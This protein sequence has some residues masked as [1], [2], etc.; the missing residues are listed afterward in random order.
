M[1]NPLVTIIMPIYNT[2]GYI[3]RAVESVLNQSFMDYE[4]LLVNDGST[5][6]SEEECQRMLQLDDRILYLSQENGGVASARNL[7]LSRARGEYVFFLDSDDTW[8]NNLLETVVGAFMKTNC[9]MVRF[10]F[11]SKAV[12]L[13]AEDSLVD[14]I[15]SQKELIIQYFTDG[16]IYRNFSA[17]WSGAYKH[18]IIEEHHLAFD[19]SLARG[20]DGKF[21]L[22]YTL[23]CKNIYVLDKKLYEYYPFFPDRENA[24]S[25]A[26]KELYDEYELCFL[27]FKMI[28]SCWEG[29]INEGERRQLYRD[30]IDRSIGRLVR[31]VAYTPVRMFW[32]N[33][34]RLGLF[35]K[36]EDVQKAATYYFPKRES[37]SKIVP[38]ALR[39]KFVLILWISLLRKK[40]T[41]FKIHEKKDFAQSVWRKTPDFKV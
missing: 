7:G 11:Q 22:S 8:K 2:Q 16:N 40:K 30:F 38:W 5:D 14:K 31:F 28:N 17:C 25:R 39:N 12:E 21:V 1:Q 19:P 18:S 13:L 26:T 32:E 15:Y 36:D 10:G 34:K 9:D 27:Q 4:L 37:D 35:C 23:H 29:L 33:Y 41:Y 6:A 24:T 20:E 3:K